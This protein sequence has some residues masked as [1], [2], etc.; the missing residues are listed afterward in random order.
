MA[1]SF[2]GR[3]FLFD[4]EHETYMRR[5]PVRYVRHP[6]ASVCSVCGRPAEPGNPLENSH[7]TPFGVG[8]RTYRLTPDYLDGKHNIVTAHKRS[9]NK[10]V[11]LSHSAILAKIAED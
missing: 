1:E 10:S 3:K 11:E 7:L 4:Y 8:V 5:M 2:E 6:K 9:C